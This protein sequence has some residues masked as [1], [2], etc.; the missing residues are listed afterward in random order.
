M[1]KMMLGLEARNFLKAS[2]D[3]VSHALCFSALNANSYALGRKMCQ[4]RPA[5]SKYMIPQFSRSTHI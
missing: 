5:L 3:D 4:I 1:L 2:A